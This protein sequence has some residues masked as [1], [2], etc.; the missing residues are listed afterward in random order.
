[1]LGAGLLLIGSLGQLATKSINILPTLAKQPE[2]VKSL[3][4][5]YPS[6]PVWFVPE[7]IAGFLL[8][9]AILIAGLVCLSIGKSLARFTKF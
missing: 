3:A 6:V 2:G 8:A 5:I 1:M 4:D 7:S 9:L